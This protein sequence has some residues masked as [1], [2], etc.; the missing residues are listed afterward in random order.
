MQ[1]YE[2]FHDWYNTFINMRAFEIRINGRSLDYR[3][4][5]NLDLSTTRNFFSRKYKVKKLWQEQRHVLGI[6]EKGGRELFLKLATTE[7]IGAVT[8]IEYKWN[9]EFNRLIS[10]KSKFWVPQNVDSGLYNRLFYLIT[11]VFKGTLLAQRPKKNTLH[12]D[13]KE[14]M[15]SVI[16][17]SELIQNIKINELSEKDSEEYKQWF[18]SKTESWYREIPDKILE[19]YKVNEL[20]YIVKKG[21]LNLEKRPRHGDFT[22]WHL[23][24]VKEEVLGLIDGEHAMKNGVEYYDIGYYLQRVYSVLQNQTYAEAIL[25]LLRKRNYNLEKL[26]IVLAARAIGGFLDE[27]LTGKPN[28]PKSND[29]KKWVIKLE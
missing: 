12:K 26:R 4:A 10:R 9:E 3:K 6:I 5:K 16:E 14:S 20:L 8:Q 11:D 27:Y 2:I 24:R 23:F 1:N 13:Y 19:K 15:V 17:F 7:G 25:N 28:Y 22:P 21:Y 18:L 29:F